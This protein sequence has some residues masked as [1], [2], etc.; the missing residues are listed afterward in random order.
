VDDF[1]RGHGVDHDF[2]GVIAIRT[3]WT[4]QEEQDLTAYQAAKL[5]RL[6][7]STGAIISYDAGS[8]DFMEVMQTVQA[9]ERLGIKT[10]LL[11]AESPNQPQNR[12]APAVRPAINRRCKSRNRARTGKLMASAEAIISPQFTPTSVIFR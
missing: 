9:C 7:G 4:A 8:N 6:L 2:A 1:Y 12:R 3:R 11:T 5:A 10:V